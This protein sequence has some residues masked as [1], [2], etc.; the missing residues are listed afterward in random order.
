VSRRPSFLTSPGCW[1]HTQRISLTAA[2]Y[3]SPI[4]RHSSEPRMAAWAKALAWSTATLFAVLL[5]VHL[6]A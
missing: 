6:L 4:E 2:E 5:A 3:A 1:I